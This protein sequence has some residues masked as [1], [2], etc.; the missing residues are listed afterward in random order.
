[1]CITGTKGAVM[2]SRKNT[3]SGFRSAVCEGGF[4]LIE[5]LVAMT[6]FAIVMAGIY[7]TYQY[8]QTSY[9]EEEKS[10]DMQQTARAA[11][12]FIGWDIRMAG[13]DPTGRADP[14][15]TIANTAEMQFEM[16]LNQDG[17]MDNDTNDPDPSEI[18]RY[19]L[20]DDGSSTARG[21]TSRN[22]T[23]NWI[24]D[25]SNP[26]QNPCRLGKE[27]ITMSGGTLSPSTPALQ[28][29]AENVDALE[30]CYV[31][32]DGTETTSPGSSQL[33][34]IRA[35]YV[36]LLFRTSGITQRHIDDKEYVSAAGDSTITTNWD[37]SLTRPDPWGPFNDAYRRKLVIVKL[38]CRN[39]G[40]GD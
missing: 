38:K 25:S 40:L 9:L 20:T 13:Y 7:E 14:G 37:G 6:I 28:P 34:D 12:Y 3:S 15:F 8:Q 1:M 5:L 17:D 27:Y 30:F 10:A 16:D 35:V 24:D 21:D 39:M 31:L 2:S 36:S 19:A 4:T 11:A 33:T 22:G 18:V 26:I 32:A 29:V 23:A